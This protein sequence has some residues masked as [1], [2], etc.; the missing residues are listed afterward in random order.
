MPPIELLDPPFNAGNY[1]MCYMHPLREDRCIKIDK[2]GCSPVQLRSKDVLYKRLRSV[3]YYDQ[4]LR[5]LDFFQELSRRVNSVE[6]Y[7]FPVVDGMVETT[8]G[9]GLCMELFRDL[10]GHVCLSLRRWI[11]QNGDS[12]A[13]R[14]ALLEMRDA[15][16]KYCAL[17]RD[18]SPSNVIIQPRADKTLRALF[19]DGLGE[20]NALPLFSKNRIFSAYR[21]RKK[22]D[23]LIRRMDKDLSFKEVR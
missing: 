17:I 10:D 22:Y 5:D 21:I 2:E 12:E 6:R 14:Q 4:N 7:Q 23:K 1:R 9:V 19:I 11:A 13:L 15:H 3:Y 18:P 20:S 16:I 8:R